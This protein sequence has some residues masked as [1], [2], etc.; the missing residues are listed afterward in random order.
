MRTSSIRLSG[1]DLLAMVSKLMF[2]LPLD[3]LK[4]CTTFNLLV[5][6]PAIMLQRCANALFAW[7]AKTAAYTT[8]YGPPLNPFAQ[9]RLCVRQIHYLF[10]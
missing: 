10:R 9:D 1:K 6:L 4:R 3:R 5:W 7:C 2:R 8:P